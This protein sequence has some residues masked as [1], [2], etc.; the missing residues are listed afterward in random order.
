MKRLRVALVNGDPGI[1]FG[2]R[3]GAALHMAAVVEAMVRRGVQV[4]VF[5]IHKDESSVPAG[6]DVFDC[7]EAARSGGTG[8]VDQQTILRNETL[9]DLLLRE[10]ALAPFD[11]IYERY[12]LFGS[13]GVRAAGKAGVPLFLEVNAPLLEEQQRY[14]SIE[15]ESQARECRREALEGAHHVLVVSRPL[16][17]Y[18]VEYGADPARTVCL[19][20]GFDPACFHT[21]LAEKSTRVQLGLDPAAFIVGF[22]GG[23]RPWHG[24]DLLLSAFRQVCTLRPDAHLLFIG[25][26]PRRAQIGEFAERYGLSQ[27][28]HVP[29]A[30]APREAAVWAAACD[31]LTAPYEQDAGDYYCPLKIPEA[32]GLGKPVVACDLPAACDYL[33]D[34]KLGL[35]VPRGDVAAFSKA[36]LRLCDDP[37]LAAELGKRAATHA[38]AH[39]TWDCKVAELLGIYHGSQAGQVL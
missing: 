26:G 39:E 38:H 16:L 29:G 15:L 1:A 28:I 19:S 27:Q 14:R 8:S 11:F 36:L 5:T 18:A 7:T 3:K 35:I 12:A 6:V 24:M 37:S 17:A 10:H 30:R 25:D 34:G 33:Q 2:G 4:T 31:V 23:L 21:G 20:N 9:M 13:A 32:M 22:S